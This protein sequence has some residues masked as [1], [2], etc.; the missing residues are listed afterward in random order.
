MCLQKPK[1]VH[2]ASKGQYSAVG[3]EV[4]VAWDGI[5]GWR[6]GGTR[7][8]IHRFVKQA[9]FYVSLIAL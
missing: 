8:S 5:H 2:T 9:K 6:M 7:R 3:G 4:Q 1:A